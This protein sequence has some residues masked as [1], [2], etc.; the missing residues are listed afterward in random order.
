MITSEEEIQECPMD[1]APGDTSV[2]PDSLGLPGPLTRIPEF[3]DCQRFIQRHGFLWWKWR[4]Y[5]SLVA[6]WVRDRLDTVS[7]PIQIGNIGFNVPAQCDSLSVTQDTLMVTPPQVNCWYG[8]SA[9]VSEPTVVSPSGVAVGLVWSD[10]D[11]YGAL[12]IKGG[13][14]CLY[15]S[16][17]AA[18]TAK[19]VPVESQKDCFENVDLAAVAGT[20][21]AVDERKFAGHGN[22][23][24]P[25]VVRWHQGLR[26]YNVG[27]KCLA[28][29]CQI[30][31]KEGFPQYTGGRTRE[32]P[33]WYD[34]Q[35]LAVSTGG[36][37]QWP[38]TILG[39]VFPDEGLDTLTH[40]GYVRKVW[41]PVAYTVVRHDPAFKPPQQDEFGVYQR[42]FNFEAGSGEE[43]RNWISF[44]FGTDVECFPPAGAEAP[45]CDGPGEGR[46]WARIVS[47]GG[48]TEY[49]CVKY[50]HH[51]LTLPGVVRW[52]WLK[53][54]DKNWISCPDGCCQVNPG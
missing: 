30:G 34:E 36:D 43:V 19:M 35:H 48:R 21:L 5:E 15:L 10:Q 28:A 31:P 11:G 8:D 25:P 2:F 18:W 40:G 12:G 14:N 6:I 39:T 54:D 38:T 27:I 7:F 50:T 53:N 29:W 17:P 42:K 1:Y 9:A 44:C 22:E 16:N 4:T 52:R 20:V 23:A 46:Y 47:A 33:G 26:R 32:I 49:R 13:W 51:G 24:F 37:E 45:K 41:A 3:H